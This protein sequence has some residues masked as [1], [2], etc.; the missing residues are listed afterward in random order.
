MLYQYYLTFKTPQKYEAKM[1][2]ELKWQDRK[3][4]T[5]SPLLF[6]MNVPLCGDSYAPDQYTGNVYG[7]WCHVTQT[8][9]HEVIHVI[10][11]L[12]RKL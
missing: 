4:Q 11:V 10:R 9:A 3:H 1:E 2:S 8:T 12:C 7:E 5:F 6:V